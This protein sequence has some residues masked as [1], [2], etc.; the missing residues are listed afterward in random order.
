MKKFFFIVLL[1]VPLVSMA[2]TKVKE[3][4]VP[5]SVL[6]TLANTYESYKVKTWYQ[7]SGQYIADFVIDGQPG[8]G[9]FTAAGDWQY[10]TFP[11]K[12]QECPTLMSSYVS[13]NYPGY[14]VKEICYVEEMGG[15][16]YYRVIIARDAL[17]A[18]DCEMIFDTRGKLMKTN[19][20]SPDAVKRDFYTRN[21]PETD[22]GRNTKAK[23]KRPLPVVDEPEEQELQPTEPIR[24]HFEKNHQKRVKRGPEWVSRDNGQRIVAYYSNAQKA[25]FEVVYNMTKGTPE[26][27]GKVLAKERYKKGIIKYLEE[28][29]K[30]QKYVIEK[31][32]VYEADSKFRD[33][34]GKKPKPYTYAV[35][36][37]KKDGKIY[38]MEFDSKDQFTG[39]LATPLDANDIQ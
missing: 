11:V 23:G 30:G 10:S 21:N 8:R 13:D 15:D 26:R 12:M 33:E 20:P 17:D 37:T 19:A 31:M 1:C 36:R 4:E 2:Q 29:F 34:T 22:D 28:K 7:A 5:K 14:K 16:N 32:V 39:L 27:L 18:A 38:R 25:E 24:A 9:Y 3:T 35:V 6:I